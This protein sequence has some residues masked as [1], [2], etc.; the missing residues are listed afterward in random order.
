MR[1]YYQIDNV[2]QLISRSPLKIFIIRLS[3]VKHA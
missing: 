3:Y 1:H 2:L